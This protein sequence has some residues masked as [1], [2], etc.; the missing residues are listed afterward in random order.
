MHLLSPELNE[1]VLKQTATSLKVAALRPRLFHFGDFDINFFP[2]SADNFRIMK[3]ICF[4]GTLGN[5]FGINA[6]V[7]GKSRWYFSH[8]QRLFTA[9]MR[10]S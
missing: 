10:S 9:L 3:C 1:A 4:P 5:A 8:N 7:F 2:N 6:E